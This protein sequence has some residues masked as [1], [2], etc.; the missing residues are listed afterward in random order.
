MK[1][2]LFVTI[3]TQNKLSNSSLY[4]INP[5]YFT[6]TF[7]LVSQKYIIC[8]CNPSVRI[9]DLVS[10]TT[11]I[12][13]YWLYIRDG[14]YG[15]KATPNDRCFE[16]HFMA[17]LFTFR[18]FARNLLRGSR[19]RKIFVFYFNVWPGALTV[20]LRLISQHTTY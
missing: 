5:T 8:H 9:I 14:T 11:Y 20:P 12:V 6:K 16:Q 18:D 15:L 3:L 7:R 17:I 1:L 2:G 4:T 19:R 10:R 13:W